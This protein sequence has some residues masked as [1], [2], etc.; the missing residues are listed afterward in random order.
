M[1]TLPLTPPQNEPSTKLI[2]NNEANTTKVRLT[3]NFDRLM[4][5]IAE[6]E[7]DSDEPSLTEIS[8]MVRLVRY[9]KDLDD[10]CT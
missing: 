9:G 10:S 8:D 6:A 2:R 5:K 4:S 1:N 3:T 7:P